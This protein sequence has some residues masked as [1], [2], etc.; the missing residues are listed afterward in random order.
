MLQANH[1]RVQYDGHPPL[2]M[3]LLMIKNVLTNVFLTQ[4]H[5]LT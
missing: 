1:R 4:E 3:S 5:M 2:F